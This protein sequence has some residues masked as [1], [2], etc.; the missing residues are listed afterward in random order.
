MIGAI[1]SVCIAA[2]VAVAFLMTPV[3]RAE[4]LLAPV[5]SSD[6]SASPILQFGA[7]EGFAGIGWAAAAAAIRRRRWLRHRAFL[8][9]MPSSGRET[10]ACPVRRSL[11]CRAQGW[12]EGEEPPTAWGCLPAVRSQCAVRE[13]GRQDGSGDAGTRMAGS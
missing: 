1:T 5:E 9:P 12:K 7:L 13:Q 10:H 8:P 11:G 3:Y 6:K 4:T 2:A